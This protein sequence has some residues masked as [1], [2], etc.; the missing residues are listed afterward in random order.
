MCCKLVIV[1]DAPSG[2]TCLL[3]VFSNGSFPEGFFPTIYDEHEVDI[4][5]DGS[6]VG[7]SLHDT[8]GMEEY[9]ALRPDIYPGSHAI[10]V[11]FAINSPYSFDSV[12]ARWIPEVERFGSGLPI[13]LV[14]CK[15]DTRLDLGA[16]NEL[17]RTGQRP[18]AFEEGVALSR[19]IGAF[20][21][22]ECSAKTGEGVRELF[23]HATRAALLAKSGFNFAPLHPHHFPSSDPKRDKCVIQ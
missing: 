11:C 17:G 18:I 10:L 14:G 21:Y 1:G 22:I 7:L 5:V 15:K 16:I 13:I 20:Q 3:T 23:E 8:S 9:S 6:R 19:R 12:E 4:E 2:K